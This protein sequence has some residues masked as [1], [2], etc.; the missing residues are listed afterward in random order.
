[1][2]Q[3]YAAKC[4]LIP[5]L[6]S[7]TF[8]KLACLEIINLA[9]KVGLSCIE[10]GG[11]VHVPH[12]DFNRAREVTRM[13]ADNDLKTSSYGSYYYCGIDRKNIAFEKILETAIELKAP[14]IRVW[15][16]KKGSRESSREERNA[17]VSD[18]RR[19]AG[20]A[21]AAGIRIGFEFHDGSLNDNADAAKRLIAEIGRPN[22]GTYWQPPRSGVPLDECLTSLQNVLPWLQNIHVSHGNSAG[23][24]PLEDGKEIWRAYL[25]TTTQK[26]RRHHALIEFVRN[27]DPEVLAND[28]S[29][30]IMLCGQ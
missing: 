22:V 17:V 19:I 20:L 26:G 14:L 11:D 18:S 4:M 25:K 7:V 27:N 16:G 6:T 2:T 21:S 10:W 9:R 12:G 13:M 5:G 29:T 23:R 24:L 1:M 15:A 30:L 3:N 8:R 28:A